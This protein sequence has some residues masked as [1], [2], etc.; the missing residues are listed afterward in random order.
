MFVVK[1]YNSVTGH[2]E[3][4]SKPLSDDSDF[5]EPYGNATE[6]SWRNG[7]VDTFAKEDPSDTHVY[8]ADT[9]S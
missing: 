7:L 1:C 6:T 2:V 4:V 5:A 9:V 8:Y 3:T